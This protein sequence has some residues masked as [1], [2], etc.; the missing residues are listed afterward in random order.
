MPGVSPLAVLPPS[1]PASQISIS[2]CAP[3]SS[4]G[5][6]SSAACEQPRAATPDCSAAG[7]PV[8]HTSSDGSCAFG[9]ELERMKEAFVQVL[10]AKG[11]GQ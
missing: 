5:S 3:G 9:Q 8:K 11:W 4:A 7:A 6:D 1:A 10:E 2:I